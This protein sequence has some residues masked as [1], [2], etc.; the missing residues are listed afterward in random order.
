VFKVCCIAATQ[1]FPA[2][3]TF[4]ARIGS[5][6]EQ[7]FAPIAGTFPSKEIRQLLE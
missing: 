1:K 6:L 4:D 7:N 5:R 3:Q 2:N